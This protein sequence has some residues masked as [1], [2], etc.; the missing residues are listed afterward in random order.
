M[1][2]RVLLQDV[3]F[4]LEGAYSTWPL[5]GEVRAN[6]ALDTVEVNFSLL[7]PVITKRN[8]EIFYNSFVQQ[9]REQKIIGKK[10]IVIFQCDSRSPGTIHSSD[11]E[12]QKSFMFSHNYVKFRGL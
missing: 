3:N 12:L 6:W 5:N 10:N 9:I 4:F 1:S 11:E 2:D 8:L 7:N